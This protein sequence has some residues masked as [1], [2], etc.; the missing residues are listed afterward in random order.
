M[1][2]L[3]PLAQ[4]LIQ[5]TVVPIVGPYGSLASYPVNPLW[6]G[7]PLAGAAPT[8]IVNARMRQ[9]QDENPSPTPF[10]RDV[11]Y[12]RVGSTLVPFLVIVIVLILL[13][14]MCSQRRNRL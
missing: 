11:E 13:V 5:T 10:S 14:E 8:V 4:P 12:Q 7:L 6:T 1:S 2:I 9:R 3:L